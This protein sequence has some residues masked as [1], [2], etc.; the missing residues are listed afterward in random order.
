MTN[1]NYSNGR[2]TIYDAKV[3]FKNFSGEPTVYNKEGDRNFCVI[4]TKELAD[5]LNEN[6]WKVRVR[7]SRDGVEP[8]NYYIKVKV[9]YMKTAPNVKVDTGS[10]ERWLDED[11]IGELDHQRVRTADLT[12]SESHW[13]RPDGNGVT[14]YLTTLFA[15]VDIDE[16][17]ESYYASRKANED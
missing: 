12:I 11:T 15:R 14:G 16:L 9:S 10:A 3:L 5:I 1:F 8:D 2:L 6:G 17:M 13:S 4:I 7:P